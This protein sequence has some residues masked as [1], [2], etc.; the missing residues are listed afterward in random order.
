MLIA[1][2]PLVAS[3][4]PLNSTRQDDVL[5]ERT[6][7]GFG[8]QVGNAVVVRDG[9]GFVVAGYTDDDDVG[10]GSRD[11]DAVVLA[12]DAEGDELWR[13]RLGGAGE[14]FGWD[15]IA[16]GGGYLVAG[17]TQSRGAGGYDAS[18]TRLTARGEV[19]W[20]KAFGGE[21][22]ER[23]WSLV[24]D[25]LG[26]CVVAAETAAPGSESRDVLLLRIDAKGDV[27]WRVSPAM[28]GDD[29]VFEVAR[30]PTGYVFAGATTTESVG[31]RDAFVL[32]VDEDGAIVKETRLGGVREVV[33]HGVLALD[34]G[35]VLVTGYGA[36]FTENGDHDALL[37]RLDANGDVLWRREVGGPGDDRAMTS[38]ADARGGFWVVGTTREG[39][40]YNATIVRVDAG[41]QVVTRT[42]LERAG[43][44][45]GVALASLPAEGCVAVGMRGGD[46]E[47]L[48]LFVPAL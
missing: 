31:E 46:T 44:D 21:G 28:P 22:D 35:G 29:R 12:V 23:G 14:D 26:G 5:L 7:G 41:G 11:A 43:N 30:T 13:A 16:S 3:L 17:F 32:H 33:A 38:A 1:L 18:L 25:G 40:D 10:D 27:R 36:S 20:E 39:G 9:G 42:E 47:E 34:D 48:W 19:V 6:Y 45:R 4:A 2:L 15:L 37:W 24:D 8:R